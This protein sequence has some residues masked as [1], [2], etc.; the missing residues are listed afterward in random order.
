VTFLRPD[1]WWVPLA[2]LVGIMAVRRLTAARAVA[3]TT[4]ALLADPAYRAPLM[5]YLPFGLVAGSLGLVSCALLQPVRP[6][7]ERDIRLQGL[8]IVLVID[9]SLSM[10]QPIGTADGSSLKPSVSRPARIQAVKQALRTFI[11]RRPGDRIGVVVFSDNS[12]VVSPLTFDHDHLLQYFS[13]I[14]PQTLRGEGRTA[15]G[16][17]IETG[18]LL[19]RRQSTSERRN[20]VL[21]VFTDGASNTGRDP[22]KSLENATRAG[23]RVHVVGVDLDQE[24]QRSPQVET[25]IEA[26]GERGGRY[27]SA[28]SSADLEAAARSLDELEQGEVIATAY[29][30]N[31][32]LVRWLALPALAMLLVGIS[33]R[34]VP[35]FVAL[36]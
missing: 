5:R 15:M 9:L 27:Y 30:R 23:T 7:T 35:I 4:V 36:H 34:A 29:V 3:V 25:L 12:Y 28:E 32:P 10:T 18:M 19:L 17:G 26:V 6:L 31:E 11:D 33:L 8:D 21:L 16:E 13:F 22:V 14:D 1:L 2:I 24:R 20:K